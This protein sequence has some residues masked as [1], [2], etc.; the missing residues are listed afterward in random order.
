MSKCRFLESR[1]S[2]LIS[3]ILFGHLEAAGGWPGKDI[4]VKLQ[5]AFIHI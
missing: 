1:I 4:E 3:K 5:L 2:I